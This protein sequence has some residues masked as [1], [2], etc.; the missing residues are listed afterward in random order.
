MY[1]ATMT[2]LNRDV[3]SHI[4]SYIDDYTTIKNSVCVNRHFNQCVMHAIKTIG[5]KWNYVPFQLAERM[6]NLEQ[7]YFRINNAADF[8]HLLQNRNKL[9]KICIMMKSASYGS[10]VPVFKELIDRYGTGPIGSKIDIK[11]SYYYSKDRHDLTPVCAILRFEQFLASVERLTQAECR[12][13]IEVARDSLIG[14]I[15]IIL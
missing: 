6:T 12:K 5:S 4:F 14:G 2:T 3:I 13:L 1:L 8:E 15:K 11:I 7:G 10:P 9:T